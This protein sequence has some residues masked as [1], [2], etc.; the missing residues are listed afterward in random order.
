MDEIKTLDI[1]RSNR[2]RP[3]RYIIDEASGCWKCISHASTCGGYPR[4]KQNDRMVYLHR[5]IWEFFRGPIPWG[6]WVLHKCHYFGAE[7]DSPACININHLALGTPKQN[8]LDSKDL[9]TFNPYFGPG[10]DNAFSKLTEKEVRE[11]LLLLQAGLFSQREI[12]A[13]Y[14]VANNTI[15]DIKTGKRWNHVTGAIKGVR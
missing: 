15:S 14:G 12:G 4:L 1:P 6:L 3:I 5:F 10:E 2:S 7:R 11:I 13:R 9:A 8:V